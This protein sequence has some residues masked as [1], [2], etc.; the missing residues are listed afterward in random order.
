M[1]FRIYKQNSYNFE[2]WLFSHLYW[3][4]FTVK[5]PGHNMFTFPVGV[6]MCVV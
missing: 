2:N 5:Y 4:S 1:E 3:L 6:T